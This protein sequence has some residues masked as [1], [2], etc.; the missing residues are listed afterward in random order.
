MKIK[1]SA[2]NQL[3]QSTRATSISTK[4]LLHFY[5]PFGR[6]DW[7]ASSARFEENELILFGPVILNEVEW[8]E[9]TIREL[10]N[11]ELPFGYRVK[12]NHKF[13]PIEFNE[14]KSYLKS[15]EE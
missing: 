8:R 12:I 6:G 4:V 1:K 11:I 14:I 5:N 2:I 9:F 13:E 7:F 15:L 10:N 3:L